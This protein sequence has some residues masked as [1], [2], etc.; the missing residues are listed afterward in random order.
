MFG[1]VRASL[2]MAGGGQGHPPANHSH[3]FLTDWTVFT[4]DK[5]AHAALLPLREAGAQTASSS[6]TKATYRAVMF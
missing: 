2:I 3:R 5:L 6:P 1:R 4:L